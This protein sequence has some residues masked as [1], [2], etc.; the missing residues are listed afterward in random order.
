[1]KTEIAAETER[2]ENAIKA[3]ESK[4]TQLEEMTKQAVLEQV[5]LSATWKAAGIQGKIELQKALFPDGLVWNERIGLFK[6][7]KKDLHRW[8]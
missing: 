3:L 5:S 6:L 1:L 8:F 2:I 7:Q 4:I